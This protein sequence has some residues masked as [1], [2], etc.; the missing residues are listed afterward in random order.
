MERERLRRYTD[1]LVQVQLEDGEELSIKMLL[2]MD[3]YSDVIC[4]VHAITK[5]DRYKVP[6]SSAGYTI[7]YEDITTFS[8]AEPN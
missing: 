1:H 4:G 2:L 6:L 7:A 3:E 8:L 5:P